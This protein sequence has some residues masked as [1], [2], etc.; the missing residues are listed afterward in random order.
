MS[1]ARCLCPTLRPSHLLC[2]FFLWLLAP[3]LP[4]SLSRAIVFLLFIL[5]FFVSTLFFPFL[6]TTPSYQATEE[7]E[8]SQVC[9]ALP[10]QIGGQTG[11][12]SQVGQKSCLTASELNGT[13]EKRE[14]CSQGSLWLEQGQWLQFKN[15]FVYKK[16]TVTS[17]EN[18]RGALSFT[19][20]HLYKKNLKM[21]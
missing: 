9:L 16:W 20:D 1:K 11:V 2:F 14:W 6:K 17:A 13:V 12:W 21:I 10:T 8:P 15:F 7:G 3:Y 5:S 18:T 19:C 4:L